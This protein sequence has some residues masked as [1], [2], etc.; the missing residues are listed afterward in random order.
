MSS[1]LPQPATVSI[2]RRNPGIIPT[3]KAQWTRFK[4]SKGSGSSP[5]YF[6]KD[7]PVGGGSTDAS[8]SITGPP[9]E[10]P[11]KRDIYYA[12]A[13]GHYSR[14][15]DELTSRLKGARRRGARPQ[16]KVNELA[17]ENDP[18]EVMDVDVVVV[19]NSFEIGGDQES[20]TEPSIE[21]ADHQPTVAL[22]P[23]PGKISGGFGWDPK[24]KENGLN[25]S[26]T[27][28]VFPSLRPRTYNC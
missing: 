14:D 18:E 22:Q 6:E 16:A 12:I 24:D 28:S 9:D 19:D 13:K 3:I 11:R 26:S 21:A 15:G 23:G 10:P 2:N 25:L 5:S 27:Q 17:M 7:F 4:Q 20:L 1:S 8:A